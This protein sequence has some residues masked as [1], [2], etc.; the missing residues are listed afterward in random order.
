MYFSNPL[1]YLDN[2]A[3][4]GPGTYLGPRVLHSHRLLRIAFQWLSRSGA[5][6]KLSPRMPLERYQAA[7]IAGLSALLT[8]G[9]Y[10]ATAS[11]VDFSPTNYR[12]S[13][14]RFYAWCKP[15][16]KWIDTGLTAREL[17]RY[18]KVTLAG[19]FSSAA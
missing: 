16:K 9:R 3:G 2:P 14:G 17:K 1:D 13:R 11:G 18:I 4:Y 15:C 19:A 7:H 5:A 6:V 12:F 10:A 8:A